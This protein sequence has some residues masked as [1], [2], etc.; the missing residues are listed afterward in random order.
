MHMYGISI[1]MSLIGK[2]IISHWSWC[3]HTV[4]NKYSNPFAKD[5]ISVPPNLD[6]PYTRSTKLIGT[7]N[8]WIQMDSHIDHQ[9]WDVHRPQ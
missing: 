4:A 3:I 1:V 6:S 7:Y 9:R 8:V 2:R 5:T